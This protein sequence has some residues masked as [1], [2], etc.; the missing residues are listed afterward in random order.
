[1]SEIPLIACEARV[2]RL[3]GLPKPINEFHK[4]SA[5]KRRT[6]CAECYNRHRSGPKKPKLS[7]T[8][9]TRICRLCGREKPIGQF[10]LRGMGLRR[11]TECASCY[12]RRRYGPLKPKV[13]LE[14]KR[15]NKCG[16]EKPVVE[17]FRRKGRP[18]GTSWCKICIGANREEFLR[19]HPEWKAEARKRHVYG[20]PKGFTS[21]LWGALNRRTI[22][23]LHPRWQDEHCRLTYLE[24]GIRLELTR[25][26]LYQFVLDNWKLIQ[27]ILALGERPSIDRID[28]A[29]HYSLDNIQIITFRQNCSKAGFKTRQQI[30]IDRKAN[31]LVL[32]FKS[33][34]AY[35][36][37][38]LWA[39]IRSHVLVGLCCLCGS[40]SQHAHHLGYS[41]ETLRGDDISKIVPL[42]EKCHYEVEFKSDGLKRTFSEML[43]DFTLK[44]S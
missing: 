19:L 12:N 3:C 39:S 26:Q 41:L 37:S 13:V 5:A 2:C 44:I 11:S 29:S 34:K 10:Q 14:F 43:E 38:A 25:E 17:F 9:L 20:S 16:D 33:Y 31:L 15:C 27:D 23:G 35:L 4:R 36:R 42:C 6:E 24:A 7:E 28:S 21:K 22:N 30:Y 8:D 1:M 40:P 18:N 32:G